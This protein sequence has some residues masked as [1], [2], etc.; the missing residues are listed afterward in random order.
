MTHIS[1]RGWP[2]WLHLP[3]RPFKKKERNSSC[4]SCQFRY[5]NVENQITLLHEIIKIK[6]LLLGEAADV[7]WLW[8]WWWWWWLG[9]CYWW[10]LFQDWVKHAW[11]GLSP[12]F[13]KEAHAKTDGKSSSGQT[14][15]SYLRSFKHITAPWSVCIFIYY[16][17]Y[18]RVVPLLTLSDRK[19][20]KLGEMTEYV[21]AWSF[22]RLQCRQLDLFMAAESGS[23]KNISL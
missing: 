15:S 2:A 3:P 19:N 12:C 11:E 10:P 22:C 5:K 17:I 20:N 18:V 23:L 13:G 9:C 1:W 16:I 21:K 14:S 6:M 8:W 7:R 4:F